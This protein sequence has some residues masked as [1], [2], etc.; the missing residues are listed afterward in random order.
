MRSTARA[1]SG[2]DILRSEL[3]IKKGGMDLGMAHEPLQSRQ[4]H[5]RADHVAA[6]GMAEPVRVGLRHT[7]F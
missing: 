7:A 4:T 5:A 3:N 2:E 6:E 1:Y